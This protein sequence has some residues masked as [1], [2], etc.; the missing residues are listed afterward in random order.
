VKCYPSCRTKVLPKF[1]VAQESPR[2]LE[3]SVPADSEVERPGAWVT[4]RSL[5]MGNPGFAASRG[6]G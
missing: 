2:A 1:S 6:L 4:D 3:V 5:R